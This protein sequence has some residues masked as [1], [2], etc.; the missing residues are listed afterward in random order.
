MRY[1]FFSSVLEQL[2]RK[3]R[4]DTAVAYAG[5]SFVKE[6]SKMIQEANPLMDMDKEEE[7]NDIY[8][9]QL[10]NMI[11]MGQLTIEKG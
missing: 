6:S 9:N 3:L 8:M 5:N 7:G 1:P 4:F 10:A 11:K 2:N